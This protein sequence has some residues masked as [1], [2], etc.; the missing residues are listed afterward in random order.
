MMS[1][2]ADHKPRYVSRSL[3]EIGQVASGH[4][5]TFDRF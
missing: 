1:E 4:M 3:I 2:H 5:A